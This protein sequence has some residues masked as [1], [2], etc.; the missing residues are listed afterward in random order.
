MP[1]RRV[2]LLLVL[3][4]PCLL[5]AQE[6]RYIDLTVVRQRTELRHPPAPPSD[7]RVGAGCLGGGYGGVSMGGGALAR[8]GPHALGIYLLCGT[9]TGTKSDG[10]LHSDFS[11]F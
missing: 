5:K 4:L 7:C 8:R 2:F 11:M 9:P 6:V 3:A 10:P 1:F